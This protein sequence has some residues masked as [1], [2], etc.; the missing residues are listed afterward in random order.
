MSLKI[1]FAYVTSVKGPMIFILY[2]QM[3]FD[4]GLFDNNRFMTGLCQHWPH[5][6]YSHDIGHFKIN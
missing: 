5:F 4:I 6:I 1:K 2:D 3:R